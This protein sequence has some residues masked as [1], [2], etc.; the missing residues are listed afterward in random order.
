[1]NPTEAYILC[2]T[3]RT[4]STFLCALL[5]S[6]GVAG[7]AESYFRE[8]DEPT[9]AVQWSITRSEDGTFSD[10]DYVRAA[11]NAGR[12]E[13]G[14][15]AVRIMWGSMES[16]I[17]KLRAIYPHEGSKP[18]DLLELAFGSTRF[19]HLRRENVLAQAISWFRA[20]QTDI[21]HQSA[22]AASLPKTP[23]PRFDYDELRRYSVLI[24]RHNKAWDLW[25]AK[26]G[27]QPY[28]LKYEDL[29]SDPVGTTCALLKFLGLQAP[30][31][32]AITAP[33]VRLADEVTIEWMERYRAMK[34][35]ENLSIP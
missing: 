23:L 17:D 30:T 1:M 8:P 3:P 16:L 33:N 18:L 21:W 15:F 7:I 22:A 29:D 6:T 19:V 12:T 10:A 4:G 9:W 13:N 14:V 5:K 27:I 25:F 32:V 20:E 24:E 31:G 34:T 2:G 28:V 35:A 26:A 11:F